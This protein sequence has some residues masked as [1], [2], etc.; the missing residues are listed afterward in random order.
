MKLYEF[1]YD[2]FG[3]YDATEITCYWEAET[4][5]KAR[6]ELKT[7]CYK[8]KSIKC[9]GTGGYDLLDELRKQE[10]V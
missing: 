1:T 10:K 7:L 5:A 9:L 3:K 4:M 8:V 6:Q 2:C